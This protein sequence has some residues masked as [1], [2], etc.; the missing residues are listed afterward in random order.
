MT[1][2]Y[3][4]TIGA[5]TARLSSALTTG[6]IPTNARYLL[7]QAGASNAGPIYIGGN[8]HGAAVSSSSFG[9]SIPKPVTSVPAAPIQISLA[10]AQSIDL[11]GFWI[12][13]TEND[14][15]HIF[16]LP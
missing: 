13:G 7:L 9:F 3:T 1:F 8:N 16:L 15:L 5:T 6:Q 4:L 2:D 12:S 10:P 14:I 11:S